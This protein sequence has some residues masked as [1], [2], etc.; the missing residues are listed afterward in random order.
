MP[1]EGRAAGRQPAA[2]ASSGSAPS[3]ARGPAAGAAA[4]EAVAGSVGGVVGAS[5][6]QSNG[7]VAGG[8]SPTGTGTVLQF[9]SYEGEL[10]AVSGPAVGMRS[11]D[12]GV[13]EGKDAPADG[14]I[15]LV[16]EGRR[17]ADFRWAVLPQKKAT[18]GKVN[19]GQEL[20]TP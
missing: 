14:S 12:V 11:R 18:P 10:T 2:A 19:N 16:G 6:Q 8:V 13:R 15:G 1:P 9:L 17:Y 3:S 7:S 4:A 5:V 20:K